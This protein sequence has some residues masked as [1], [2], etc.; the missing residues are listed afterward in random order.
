MP[1]C[2]EL[3]SKKLLKLGGWMNYGTFG[4]QVLVPIAATLSRDS[5]TFLH[6]S[7]YLTLL[8][9][10]SRTLL[11]LVQFDCFLQGIGLDFLWYNFRNC[12]LRSGLHYDFLQFLFLFFCMMIST[13]F[14]WNDS[15]SFYCQLLFNRVEIHTKKC[16]LSL[17]VIFNTNWS[18]FNGL[19]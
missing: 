3:H 12:R 16:I 5:L 18:V 17:C 19:V 14:T 13:N 8:S 6:R 15:I 9:L 4:G 10:T 1:S 7:S 2:I 11:L